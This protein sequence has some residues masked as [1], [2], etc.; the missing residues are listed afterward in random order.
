MPAL[1]TLA[2]IDFQGPFPSNFLTR[3]ISWCYYPQRKI[4]GGYTVVLS[5]QDL[6][7]GNYRVT[8]SEPVKLEYPWI[9]TALRLMLIISTLLGRGLQKVAECWDSGYRGAF[10]HARLAVAYHL[11]SSSEIKL[12]A[13]RIFLPLDELLPEDE[14][15]HRLAE[16]A[17]RDYF[18]KG[19]TY[20]R[21]PQAS[22]LIAYVTAQFCA[23]FTCRY[24]KQKYLSQP[25]LP[26]PLSPDI[27]G[28]DPTSNSDIEH[29]FTLTADLAAD[30]NW[31]ASHLLHLISDSATT[32]T[33]L[34]LFYS[35]SVHLIPKTLE[36][37][38]KFKGG[39]MQACL[40]KLTLHQQTVLGSLLEKE[41]IR[42]Q[43]ALGLSTVFELLMS[44]NF[45][46]VENKP[47]L[48]QEMAPYLKLNQRE[49]LFS[50]IEDRFLLSYF[51]SAP[52]Q[53]ED[54]CRLKPDQQA[55]LLKSLPLD[56]ALFFSGTTVHELPLRAFAQR[57]QLK[58]QQPEFC[59]EVFCLKLIRNDDSQHRW[60]FLPEAGPFLES[61]LDH[62]KAR[63]DQVILKHLCY[64]VHEKNLDS[65]LKFLFVRLP[66]E[67]LPGL[68][69]HL[70]KK[71]IPRAFDFLF[72]DKSRRE[73][74]GKATF[75][76]SCFN[77]HRRLLSGG[78]V[79]YISFSTLVSLPTDWL[80]IVFQEHKEA[81][82]QTIWKFHSQVDQEQ[83]RNYLS[84]P[85]LIAMKQFYRHLEQAQDPNFESTFHQWV[86]GQIDEP[87]PNKFKCRLDLV[88]Q[89]LPS[90][91]FN[92]CL[93]YLLC[94]PDIAF[95]ASNGVLYPKDK[96][97]ISELVQYLNKEQAEVLKESIEHGRIQPLKKLALQA[98]RS[99]PELKLHALQQL[100]PELRELI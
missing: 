81:F 20:L 98:V 4:Y 16:L 69:T 9:Q 55:F 74:I 5:Q 79:Y 45:R 78:D 64:A 99:N 44:L 6:S 26:A 28:P 100:P 41:F 66:S 89:H 67:M 56:H 90:Q 23:Q 92:T 29:I 38:N 51:K 72:K 68:F 85:N 53:R 12:F 3:A 63:Q 77:F 48:L 25:I 21:D 37:V 93:D 97:L 22:S 94:H 86:I 88:F 83:I 32:Q 30:P 2:S 19:L 18:S 75:T 91:Y 35:S 73:S 42:W 58:S 40:K 34:P 33:H 7:S 17:L 47:S 43:S 61:V 71:F 52:R 80:I 60:L 82:V 13:Q 36:T 50:I 70:G 87:A 14:A 84:F 65:A 54:Y 10:W 27:F 49:Q 76:R 57:I 96:E 1:N 95:R 15:K 39:M 11:L 8:T 24:L 46:G 31:G 62:L 59:L